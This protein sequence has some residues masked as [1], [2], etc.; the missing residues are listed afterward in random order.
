ML[1]VIL[2][3]LLYAGLAT[4]S[5]VEYELN[6]NIS[7]IS[8]VGALPPTPEMIAKVGYKEVVYDENEKIP[9]EFDARKK[10]PNCTSL[11]TIWD[12]GSCNS[13]WAVAS[14]SAM[15]DRYCIR[16]KGNV[17]LSAYD[18]MSCCNKCFS[19]NPCNGGQPL[20]AWQHWR[21]VGV[22]TGGP[23]QCSGCTCYRYKG[24]NLF[25]C[26]HTCREDYGK[27]YDSDLTYGNPPRMMKNDVKRIQREIMNYGPVVASFEVF[28]DFDGHVDEVY[29]HKTGKPLGYHAVRVIGWGVQKGWFK[30]VPYWLAVN[31][32]GPQWKDGGLFRILRGEN[33]CQFESMVVAD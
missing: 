3:A 1:A 27:S 8:T 14:A 22:V 29:I 6:R 16:G 11:K 19:G 20:E 31:S 24:D 30:N 4:N 28:E 2:L 9:E 21:W 5:P 15:G 25:K 17:V 7:Q 12:Q 23:T 32:R 26:D 10:W 13:C 33:H 18:I